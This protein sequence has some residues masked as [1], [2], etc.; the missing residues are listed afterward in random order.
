[1]SE[2]WLF[3]YGTLR[4]RAVQLATFGRTLAG[5]ADRLDGYRLDTIVIT[6]PGVVTLSGTETHLIARLSAGAAIDGT[7]LA[8]AA[9]EVA[10]ADDYETA[11]YVRVSLALASGRQAFV[12]VATDAATGRANVD[13]AGGA[14]DTSA[15]ALMV[16]FE[17][18]RWRRR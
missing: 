2:A 8:V 11:D 1:M 12:Y 14:A 15:S 13:A 6:E 10:A 18:R 16:G 5:E 7:V 17:E 9:A 4:L 3:S